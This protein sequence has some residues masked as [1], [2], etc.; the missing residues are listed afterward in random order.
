[1]AVT[2]SRDNGDSDGY[3]LNV[4]TSLPGGVSIVEPR[5]HTPFV[6]EAASFSAGAYATYLAPYRDS[7]RL[8]LAHLSGVGNIQDF[9]NARGAPIAYRHVHGQWPLEIYQTTY[10]SEPGSAEMPSAGRPFTRAILERLRLIGVKIARIVLHA[11]VSSLER[12]EAPYEEYFEV[13][14]ETAQLIAEARAAGTRVIAVGTTSVRAL[15]SA[16]D[17]DGRIVAA[18]GWTDLIITPERGVRAIDGM[19]TGLHEPRSSHLS[20][21]QALAGP[22]HVAHAYA[23]AL[24]GKYLWHE[25]GDSHLLLRS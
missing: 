4:S 19:L 5:N 10:A 24:A 13:P 22:E 6:G 2:R 1:L 8:W 23:E 20:M 11:G 16:T 17:R 3:T 12:D 9:L 14:A 18:Q 7:K 15:E 25:F 21:L